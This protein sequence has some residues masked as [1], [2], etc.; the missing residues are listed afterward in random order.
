MQYSIVVDAI[1][2]CTLINFLKMSRDYIFKSAVKDLLPNAIPVELDR[3][4]EFAIGKVLV[5]KKKPT[6]LIP[7]RQHKLE[8]TEWSLDS[9]LAENQ[10]L[11]ITTSKKYL[12]D[13]GKGSSST[14]IKVNVEADLDLSKISSLAGGSIDIKG[15]E[16]K[17][18][19]MSTDFGK[20]THIYS[21]LAKL[22]IKENVVV[23]MDHPLVK[24]ARECGGAMFVIHTVYE[25]EH[26]NVSIQVS[27]DKTESGSESANMIAKESVSEKVEEK[28]S[29]SKGMQI[30]DGFIWSREV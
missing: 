12:Y 14:T 22:M 16:N 11:N 25:A 19:K 27:E 24:K 18:L 26:C 21:D 10:Q 3:V 13:S 7:M 28:H 29:S 30:L 5:Y 6:K 20:I 2:F 1:Q 8:F 4:D 23:K 17:V 15:S 9:L